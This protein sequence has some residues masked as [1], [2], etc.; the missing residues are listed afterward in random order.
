M[1]DIY[2]EL[3]IDA[4]QHPHHYGE[5]VEADVM[6]RQLNPACGDDVTVYLRL[7]DDQTAIADV[8]WQGQGCIVSRASMSLLSDRLVGMSL[9]AVS[10]LSKT[11]LE[12]MLGF[13]DGV[14]PGRE[15]C[16]LLGLTAV[17]KALKK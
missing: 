14:A 10:R 15:K 3:I 11:D 9:G 16:M 2:H 4:A 12:E 17:N 13:V 5:M 8:L 1:D 7:N 6:T